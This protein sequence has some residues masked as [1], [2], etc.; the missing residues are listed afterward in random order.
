MTIL[1]KPNLAILTDKFNSELESPVSIRLFTQN[2][3]G[4]FIPGRK[5]DTCSMTEKI[6]TEISNLSDK[7]NLEIIDFYQD[8]AKSSI[9]KIDRIPA[10][11]IGQAGRAKYYGIPSGYEFS[12]LVNS[13][14]NASKYSQSLDEDIIK[15]L[16]GIQN[17]INIKVFV[18][19]SCKFCPKIA[20]LALSL[21]LRFNNIQADVIEIQEYPELTNNYHISSVPVTIINDQ[22]QLA[23]QISSNT[24]VENI[25]KIDQNIEIS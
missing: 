2:N 6:L 24:L 10:T 15:N 11:I 8:A 25:V 19:P 20:E 22:I 17:L 9:S 4:L 7:L 12:T 21:A 13:I 3:T 5:C 14:I 18:T 23:G 1:D 16:E